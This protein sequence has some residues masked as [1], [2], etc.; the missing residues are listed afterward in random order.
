MSLKSF[1]KFCEKM[2]LGEPASE[3]EIMDER[4]KIQRMRIGIETLVIF[5]CLTFINCLIMDLSYQWAESYSAP[6]L[7][8]FMIC[9]I[10]FQIRCFSA[11]CMIGINGTFKAKFVAFY[12]IFMG[13][14]FLLSRDWAE[15]PLF[16]HGKMTDSGAALITWIL[17]IIY[18]IVSL[19]LVKITQKNEKK[20]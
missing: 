5:S 8:F 12:A 18:G 4:Q 1:D 19:I 17:F 7:L 15:N 20:E 14:V 2:I 3:K 13:A 16:E 10:Y 11:G 6:I 9:M